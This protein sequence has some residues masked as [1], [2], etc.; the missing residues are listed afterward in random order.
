MYLCIYVSMYLC[1][2]VHICMYVFMSDYLYIYTRF[3]T[4][5]C[6]GAPILRGRLHGEHDE[7]YC[8]SF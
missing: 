3:D 7:S 6:S 5:G 2:Y 1:V 8:T 4:F